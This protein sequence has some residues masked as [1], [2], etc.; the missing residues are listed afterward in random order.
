MKSVL[1]PVEEHAFIGAVLETALL[2]ARKF[3][4][5][6]EGVALGPD[7]AELAAADFSLSGVVIDERTRRDFLD[8]GRNFFESF[9][10]AN[11]VGRQS[12]VAA[13]PTFGW[14]G[15]GLLSDNGVGEYG[16]IF[17]LIV[18]GRPGPGPRQPRKSTFE[19]ALFESGRPVLI[20]PPRSLE[21]LGETIVIVW[22]GST[23]TARTIA[24]AMPLLA[25]A[26]DVVVLN[27]PGPRM[28]GPTEEQLAKSLRR[29]D[30]PARVV[31]I[32][33]AAKSA[34]AALLETAA[35]LGA[36]LLVKG[37]YTRSRL[38]QFIFGNVTSEIL[39]HADVP[40]FM[41]H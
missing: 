25:L 28:P 36:D 29:H 38:R 17:D 13:A 15:D 22:N 9:M 32:G 7:I 5:Y 41:A 4:S 33:E 11:N 14:I 1:V 31:M 21:T 8:H 19:A 16:R 30:V 39:A 40:V 26:K 27:V 37:G 6:V 34:G 20:A 12:A 2:F 23:D 18:V 3:G 10:Q 24:F 35:M